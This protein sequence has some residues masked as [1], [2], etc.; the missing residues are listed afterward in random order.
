[1]LR[2]GSEEFG[3]RPENL[4]ENT[5]ADAGVPAR[6]A[7]PRGI[8]RDD[9]LLPV[10]LGAIGTIELVSND[11]G[12]LWAS[13]GAYWFTVA[14]LCARRAFPLAMP[15]GAIGILVGARLLG[16][17]TDDSAAW[18]L[19][20]ALAFYSAGRHVPRSRTALPLAAVLASIALLMLNN[21]ASLSP[22]IV[23]VVPFAVAS[24]AVGVAVRETLERTR[25]LAAR[26]E[27]A[28]LE[29]ELEAE[30]VTPAERKRI[31]R[32]LHDLLANSL[33]VMIVQASL[34]TDLVVTD[35]VR[36]A[37]AVSEVEQSGRAALAETRR[38]LR[39]IQ[40]STD[41]VAT[42]PPRGV[43]EIPALAAEYTGAGL[44]IDLE[45]D[46]VERLPAGPAPVTQRAGQLAQAGVV[47]LLGALRPPRRHLA[48]GLVPPPAQLIQAPRHRRERGVG[49][50]IGTL[51][52][53]LRQG[54]LHQRQAPVVGEPGRAGMPN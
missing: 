10:L 20:G 19:T 47:G 18:I 6:M 9:V 36:A 13:L 42:H 27:R 37:R 51:R 22:D 49:H 46:S 50:P 16:A 5:A 1:L 2:D 3:L 44:G 41:E 17:N 24:W 29:Q 15:I 23:F 4:P 25:A 45:L 21:A 38:L 8:R 35:P 34:A 32:E 54:G 39:L 53:A 14:L 30:R 7:S 40:G 28:R 48:L 11:Y 31:A 33:T 52:G 12:P 26:T 43:A